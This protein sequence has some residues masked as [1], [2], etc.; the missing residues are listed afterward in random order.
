VNKKVINTWIT[1][2]ELALGFTGVV[3]ISIVGT[4]TF[5]GVVTERCG[6]G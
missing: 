5:I 3:L 1:F 6:I 4:R 2:L